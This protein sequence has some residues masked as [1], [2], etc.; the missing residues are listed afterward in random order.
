MA[1]ESQVAG[2]ERLERE[3]AELLEV[4]QFE[5]PSQFREQG[6]LR[7]ASVY[8]QAARDPLGWWARQAEELHWFD[9]WET[10]LDD[11]DPPFYK[12]FV[13]GTLNAS[14]NC[15]DRHVEAGRGDR[16]AFHWRGEEGEE[17]D[18]TYAQLLSEVKRLAN[19]L[20]ALGIGKGDVVGIY[21]PMIPE[22][23]VSMLAC[24]RIGA[25]HNV[26]FGGFAAEAVR[27]RMEF[28]QAKAL[29]TVDGAA[30]KGNTAPVKDRVDEVMG[31]L[32]TLETIIVV[33]SKGTP[34][35]MREGRDVYYD[36][37][38]AAADEECAAEPLDAPAGHGRRAH[39]PQGVALVPQGDRR[40][41]LPDRGHLVADRDG[42]DHDHAA[43]GDHRDEARIGH[44]S[45]PR[46]VRG[47]T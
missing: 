43:A 25:P 6:L 32:P 10:V 4:R 45:L 46:G 23:V 22:V 35:Q 31:D 39:Q 14:Y 30:R 16:V 15:L 19:A 37:A 18:V 40:R 13:G 11:S 34:C 29:I 20:K 2:S 26:V 9:R 3:L 28:S 33:R 5:P 44:E 17:R 47:G 36:E 42:R 8:G 27:E 41:A 38:V 1:S 21:L 24:A 12:W 7:D